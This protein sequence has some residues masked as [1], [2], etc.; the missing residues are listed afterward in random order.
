[1]SEGG[2][3][4]EGGSN[5]LTR[6]RFLKLAATGAAVVAG[7]GVYSRFGELHWIEVVRRPL[8]IAG[9]PGTLQGRTL[10]QLSDLHCGPRVDDDY[11]R[12]ALDHVRALAPDILVVTGDFVTGKF[13]LEKA[14][15]I[16]THLPRGRLATLGILGNHDYGKAWSHPEFANA[17]VEVLRPTGIE[18]LRNRSRDVSGLQFVGCDDL[19]AGRLDARAALASVDPTRPMLAMAHNPDTADLDV[20]QGFRGWIL[21]GHTHGGQVRLWP[22]PPPILPVKNR[23]YAAGEARASADRRVYVN[24]GVGHMIPWRFG[25]RPEITVFTLTAGVWI[26]DSPVD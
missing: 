5:G 18:I 4:P 15:R 8:P 21:S 9:L 7:T 10:I 11:L 2:A 26:L 17:V 6:R 1:V 3:G 22:F 12:R 25:V 14:P 13:G 16:Y 24:R 19:W 20:W 23:R